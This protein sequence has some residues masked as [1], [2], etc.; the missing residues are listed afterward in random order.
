MRRDGA[1]HHVYSTELLFTPRDKGQDPRHVDIIWPLWNLFD[2]T[3]E[4]RGASWYPKLSY[5]T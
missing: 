4:G 5:G 3:P 2:F 1:V